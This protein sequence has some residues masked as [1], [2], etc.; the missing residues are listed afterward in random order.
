MNEG[1]LAYKTGLVS[2]PAD[3]YVPLMNRKKELQDIFAEW[4][5]AKTG[6]NEP[7]LCGSGKKF[8]KCCGR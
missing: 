7:C 6:R 8:K 5:S 4:Q 2:L 1:D 3:V